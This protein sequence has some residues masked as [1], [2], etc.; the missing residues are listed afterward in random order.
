MTCAMCPQEI[1]GRQDRNYCSNAC[2]QKAYRRR[3][4]SRHHIVTSA[5]K[6]RN[7]DLISQVAKLYLEEGMVVADVTFGSGFFWKK[8]NTDLYDFRPTDLVDGVDFRDLPYED[9]SIDVLAL[10]P[11][12]LNQ[13]HGKGSKVHQTYQATET[14]EALG[15]RGNDGV[16]ELYRE[17]LSEADRVVRPEGQ[18]WVKCQDSKQDWNHITIHQMAVD[19]GWR[20]RD[21]F[22]LVTNGTPMR[23][24]YQKSAKKTHSYLWIFES[25]A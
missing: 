1:D 2:R 4:G 8:V 5:V 23:W 3:N 11:P 10:D 24:P 15:I 22:V 25:A 9:D 13:P 16:M 17:G 12:Y 18:V 21:L 14:F 19:L 20:A 7:A 6:G